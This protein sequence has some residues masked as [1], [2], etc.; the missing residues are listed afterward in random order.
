VSQDSDEGLV[1]FELEPVHLHDGDMEKLTLVDGVDFILSED[2][3]SE[4]DEGKWVAQILQ[5]KYNDWVV[6][7]PR[8]VLDK[9]ELDFNYEVLFHPPFGDEY[10]LDE[11]DVA[12]YMGELLA[13]VLLELQEGKDG[14]IYFDQETGEQID[15]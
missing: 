4:E 11:L 3:T 6:R 14:L 8:I 15:I 10:E 1:E 9:G 7:F 12:N 2:P 13:T 5:G